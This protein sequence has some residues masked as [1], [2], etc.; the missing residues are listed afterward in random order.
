M[1][2]LPRTLSPTSARTARCPPSDPGTDST[3]TLATLLPR[4]PTSP[5]HNNQE[6]C[7]SAVGLRE[8]RGQAVAGGRGT[9]PPGPDGRAPARPSLRRHR[10]RISGWREGQRKGAVQRAEWITGWAGQRRAEEERRSHRGQAGLVE[11]GTTE[12]GRDRGQEESQGGRDRG[13]P[14]KRVEEGALVHGKGRGEETAITPASYKVV[15]KTPAK[16]P[17]HG[18]NVNINWGAKEP[19]VGRMEAGGEPA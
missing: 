8:G 5:A 15:L 3:R 18:H 2:V 7:R 16:R 9:P 1:P 4:L 12:G 14:R 6:T 11:G 19:G 10:G 17:P 13:V